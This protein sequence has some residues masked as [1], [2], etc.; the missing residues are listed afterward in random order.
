VS[1][2]QHSIKTARMLREAAVPAIGLNA[3]ALAV[4]IVMGSFLATVPALC[5][6]ALLAFIVMQTRLIGDLQR[7]DR[8]LSRPHM[9]ADDYRQLREMEIELGWE[10]SEPLMPV[11]EAHE[12]PAPVSL[13]GMLGDAQEC[14]CR[15]ETRSAVEVLAPDRATRVASYCDACGRRIREDGTTWDDVAYASEASEHFAQLTRVGRERCIGFCPFCEE[16]RHRLFGPLPAGFKE[17]ASMQQWIE[18][19]RWGGIS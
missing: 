17:D 11:K 15:P 19:D 8:E 12:K 5:L 18:N 13:Y 1:D 3:L 9:T 16:R 14:E 2:V 7:R 10:P 4:L 6:A